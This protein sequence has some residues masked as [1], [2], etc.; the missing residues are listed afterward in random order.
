MMPVAE[1]IQAPVA[2]PVADEDEVRMGYG[3]CTFSGC[4]CQGYSADYN[5]PDKKCYCTHPYEDH[6]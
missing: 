2:E 6:R 5:D 4:N 3:A 1:L